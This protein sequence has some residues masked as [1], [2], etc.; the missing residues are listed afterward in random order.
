MPIPSTALAF[1][2]ADITA[3]FADIGRPITVGGV[4]AKGFL[5]EA[6]VI[7]VQDVERGQ[8]LVKATTLIVQTSAFPGVAVGAAVIVNSKSFTVRGR[9]PGDEDGGTMKLE[10]GV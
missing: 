8:V 2:D 1:G 6:D 5:N 9:L 10:L 3:M 4:A 7:V